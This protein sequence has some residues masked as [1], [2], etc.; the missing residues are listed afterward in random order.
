MLSG[1]V[2]DKYLGW[3]PYNY[4]IN[5]LAPNVYKEQKKIQKCQLEKAQV[6]NTSPQKDY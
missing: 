1:G 6:L 2:N 5:I 3:S 4:C